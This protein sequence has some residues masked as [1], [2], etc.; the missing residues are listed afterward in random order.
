MLCCVQCP[1]ADV[2]GDSPEGS[3]AARDLV[4]RRTPPTERTVPRGY[5][6][7]PMPSPLDGVRRD[8]VAGEPD[9]A[10]D[11]SS[12]SDGEDPLAREKRRLLR[13]LRGDRPVDSA[14]VVFEPEPERERRRSVGSADAA[15]PARRSYSNDPDHLRLGILPGS[16]PKHRRGASEP[17]TCTRGEDAGR[18]RRRRLDD[19]WTCRGER[20]TTFGSDADVLASESFQ[21]FARGDG[22]GKG[23]GTREQPLDGTTTSPGP[24]LGRGADDGG[25]SRRARVKSMS[26]TSLADDNCCPTCFEEYDAENPKMSLVCGHHFHLGCI[27]EWYERSEL[28][29]VCE[30]KMA[31]DPSTG[32]SLEG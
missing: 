11:S 19:S 31:F 18:F 21:A 32:W 20:G 30:E 17:A 15:E 24:G 10:A 4:A 27:Y 7:P 29:P 6:A 9:D 23:A 14:D 13:R 3:D 12:G 25:K 28:C 2:P 22:D 8:D 16:I 5:R 26:V 1:R